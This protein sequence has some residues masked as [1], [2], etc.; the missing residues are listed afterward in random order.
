M[1]NVKTFYVYAKNNASLLSTHLNIFLT[2][3]GPIIPLERPLCACAVRKPK[4]IHFLS[5]SP[6]IE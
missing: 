5:N 3:S 6:I 4:A 2:E 1:K